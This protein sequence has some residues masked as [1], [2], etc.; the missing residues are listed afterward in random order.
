MKLALNFPALLQTFFTDR[1]IALRNASP[2]TIAAY[3]DTFR[4]LFDYA[5]EQLGKAPSAL[6]LEDL[7]SSFI[8]A[9]LEHLERDRGNSARSRNA[10]LSAVHSF[11]HYVAYQ[12][13]EHSSLVQRVLAI[14]GKK[15]ERALVEY[16]NEDE[17]NA[18]LDAPDRSTFTGRRD[19][20]LMLIG[21]QTGLR[22]SELTGLCCR[23]VVFGTGAHVRCVGKGR[24]ARCTPLTQSVAIV[25][26]AWIKERDAEPQDPLFPNRRG[27]RL[28][29]DGVQFILTKHVTA[30]EPQCSSLRE[31]KVSPHVLRHT[32]AMN[33]L[34]AGGDPATIA[35]WLGH[36]R[37]ETVNVYVQADLARKEEIL[38]KTTTPEGKTNRFRPDDALLTFL[39][40]L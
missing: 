5:R 34:H 9:F 29:S 28:S 31:K 37:L 40:S 16:L 8:G 3:R 26:K 19:H 18:L 4:L 1:L 2:N 27:G 7:N 24:K 14:P 35:L 22:V 17:T 12:L 33:L 32:A 36:E 21:I 15:H 25:V 11:F 23:D 10:R 20:A 30:A 38:A 13:P 39:K 6:T